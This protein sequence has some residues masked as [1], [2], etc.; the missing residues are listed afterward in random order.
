MNLAILKTTNN[1]ITAKDLISH[2]ETELL[3]KFEKDHSELQQIISQL[4]NPEIIPDNERI[5]GLYTNAYHSVGNCS[6]W[7]KIIKCLGFGSLC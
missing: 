7:M 3:H 5:H 2:I 4:K 6:N 1:G